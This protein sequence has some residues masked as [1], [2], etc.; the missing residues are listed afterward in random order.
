[1]KQRKVWV[2]SPIVPVFV[3]IFLSVT[4]LPGFEPF[5]ESIQPDAS[6]MASKI[7]P[8]IMNNAKLRAYY[9]REY[10][11]R[12]AYNRNR[13]RMDRKF[14]EHWIDQQIIYN[15][16]VIADKLKLLRNNSAIGA[17]FLD[18]ME[19]EPERKDI[20]DRA[21]SFFGDFRNEVKALR[22]RI[23]FVISGLDSKPGEFHES[24]SM[25]KTSA[26]YRMDLL[27]EELGKADRQIRN[28]FL[29][30]THTVEV[31]DLEEN[32]MMIR[33]YRIE[34]ILESL[35]KTEF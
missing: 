7:S 4:P 5:Q 28:Y 1:M 25:E 10:M 30:P 15:A 26:R 6:E 22:S 18:R 31:R 13:L 19:R 12:F 11:E 35:E 29:E 24:Y 27:K 17:Q 33:L 14:I 32:N 23:D 8:G 21:R 9:Y 34:K 16:Q 3:I 20:K 2:L